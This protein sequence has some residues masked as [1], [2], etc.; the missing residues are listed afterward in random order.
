MG[1]CDVVVVWV[2]VMW[3]GCEVVVVWCGDGV[4]WEAKSLNCV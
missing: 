2:V 3:W 1:C 4:K